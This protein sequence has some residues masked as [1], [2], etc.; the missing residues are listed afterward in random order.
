M[1]PRRAESDHTPD[2]AEGFAET[3]AQDQA[4]A[5][6]TT[7]TPTRTATWPRSPLAS[8]RSSP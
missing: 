1:P 8:E 5:G 7:Q 3:E 4:Q 6:R 2:Q